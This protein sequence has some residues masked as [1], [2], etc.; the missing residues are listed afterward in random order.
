MGAAPSEY[1]AVI[2]DLEGQILELQGAVETLKRQ[3]DKGNAVLPPNTGTHT[4]PPSM[5]PAVPAGFRTTD[6]E[7]DLPSTHFMNMSLPEA[8]KTYLSMV[9]RKRSTKQLVEALERGGYPTRSKKFFNTVFGVI[10]RH[11]KGPNPEIVKVGTD[12]GLAEWYRAR[13][14]E[15]LRYRREEKA[16]DLD[17]G[18]DETSGT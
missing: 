1:D 15:K 14:N 10:N 4:L 13:P 9:K 6:A 8:V 7:P 17:A 11:A 18:G 12:W 5:R 16:S 3:R 2:A